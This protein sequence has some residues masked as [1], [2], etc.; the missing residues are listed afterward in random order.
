[1]GSDV[2]KTL[3][4]VAYKKENK[5]VYEKDGEIYWQ[6][7]YSVQERKLGNSLRIEKKGL[8]DKA[9]FNRILIR[10]RK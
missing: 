2:S 3:E 4:H 7:E 5:I 9:P 8:P 6:T 10:R 1:M